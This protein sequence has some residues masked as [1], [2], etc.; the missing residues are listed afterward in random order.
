M[1]NYFRLEM[2]SGQYGKDSTVIAILEIPHSGRMVT[3]RIDFNVA[4]EMMI[5]ERTIRDD[6]D[7]CDQIRI[8]QHKSFFEAACSYGPMVQWL[9]RGMTGIPHAHV[10]DLSQPITR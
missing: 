2:H 7:I 1:N 6:L 9:A 3:H 8:E 5:Y 4:S 10:T